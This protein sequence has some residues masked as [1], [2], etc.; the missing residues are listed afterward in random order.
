M[1]VY[2]K[3]NT[4][5]QKL[6]A[7]KG[8]YNSFGKYYYRSCED[9]LEGV[10]SLLKETKT[11]LTITDDLVLIGE[12][13]YLKATATLTDCET[14]DSVSNSAFAREE[15]T[16]KGMSASQVTGATSSYARKYALNGLF[17]IDD[18]ADADTRN[19]SEEETAPAPKKKKTA[20]KEVDNDLIEQVVARCIE[21]C[22]DIAKVCQLYKVSSKNEL[23][24]TYCEN[25]LKNWDKV[26][27]KVKG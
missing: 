14:G 3:L 5:Q 21:D 4:I 27:S 22:I 9:I 1:S 24:K 16:F 25:A 17:C 8:Q 18:V 11:T 7:P 12:R 13:Y 15:E 19:N 26:K 6:V 20:T 10:K 2:D 23:T